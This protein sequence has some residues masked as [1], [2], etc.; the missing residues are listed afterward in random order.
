MHLVKDHAGKPAPCLEYTICF[1]RRRCPTC[2]KLEVGW[3]GVQRHQCGYLNCPSCHEYVDAQTHRCFIQ[4]ALSPQ[5]LRAQKK[6]RKRRTGSRAE[7]AATLHASEMDEEALDDDVGD[8]DSPPLHV[9]FDIEA[10]QPHEKHV[11]NLVVAE[12]DEDNSPVRFPGP[13]CIRDFLEWL[14]T[15]TEND[16]RAV[17]VSSYRVGGSS[18]VLK[19]C[20][21]TANSVTTI[22]M[23]SIC[24]FYH[25][26]PSH[27]SITAI[28]P[29]AC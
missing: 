13:H 28:D 24:F 8:D 23:K 17:N 15:L 25:M 16:T 10:M 20:A 18:T 5:E 27:G 12:T 4:R 1:R 19:N 14:D 21:E 26:S 22:S 2:L 7:R 29:P 11:P 9:F 6:K 3:Q